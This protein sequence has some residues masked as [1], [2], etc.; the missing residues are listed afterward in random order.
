MTGKY[1]TTYCYS[2]GVVTR[3]Q[4]DVQMCLCSRGV[5]LVRMLWC[6]ELCARAQH[7]GEPDIGK[8]ISQKASTSARVSECACVW[9][10]ERDTERQRDNEGDRTDFLFDVGGVNDQ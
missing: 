9:V 2:V 8:R 6:A 5:V 10:G 1:A 3:A 7:K 4:K